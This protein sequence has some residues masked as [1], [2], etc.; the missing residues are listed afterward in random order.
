MQN[1]KY[2]AWLYESSK[3]LKNKNAR[4]YGAWKKNGCNFSLTYL[5]DQHQYGNQA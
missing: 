1:T 3:K 2:F 5:E 4:L